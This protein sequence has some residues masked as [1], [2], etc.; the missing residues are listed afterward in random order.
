MAAELPKQRVA[1]LLGSVGSSAGAEG[2]VQ[3]G[4]LWS[5]HERASVRTRDAGAAAQRIAATAV[6]QRGAIDAVADRARA[7]SSRAAELQSGTSRVLDVFDRLGLVALNAGLEG[8]RLGAA[9]GRAL[10]LV[11]DEVRAHS[12][13][14]GDAARELSASLVQLIAELGHLE[15]TV[16]Q[17]Q[18]V[19]AEVTQDA[20]RAAGAASD[21]EGALIDMGERVR[22]ATGTDP[23]A[24]R[25]VAEAGERARA[26]V[27]SLT[28]LSK[29]VP[30]GLLASALYPVLEPLVSL[31]GADQHEIDDDP[32]GG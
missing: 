3:D 12:S 14:G 13:R 28:A 5:A 26:L 6:R 15:S 11:G 7:M 4:A 17:A 31:L 16:G 10:A 20:A 19:V 29:T 8:A 23:A 22:R 21:V 32:K 1:R 25:A 30:Q 18:S 24:V 27:A 9:E 2:A